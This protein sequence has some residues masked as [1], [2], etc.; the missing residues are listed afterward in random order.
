MPEG[1]ATARAI[2]Y[3]LKRDRA[4]F[5]GGGLPAVVVGDGHEAAARQMALRRGEQGKD[6]VAEVDRMTTSETNARTS[7]PAHWFICVSTRPYN[8]AITRP[9]MSSCTLE[10]A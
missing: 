3:S 9:P 5:Q 4:A 1:S 10:T 7:G 2:D 6:L 8:T